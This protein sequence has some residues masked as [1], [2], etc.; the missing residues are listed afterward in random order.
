MKKCL[1]CGKPI[2]DKSVIDFCDKCGFGVFGPKMLEAIKKNMQDA[3]KRG[4]L[5]QG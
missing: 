3:D 5:L 1:Y 4:D 2:E